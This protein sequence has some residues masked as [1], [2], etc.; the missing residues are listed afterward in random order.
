ME[1]VQQ[2]T[3]TEKNLFLFSLPILNKNMEFFTIRFY[4]YFLETESVKLFADTKFEK[5]HKMFGEAVNLILTYITD[6][7]HLEKHIQIL[8][9]SHVRYGVEKNNINDFT[10]SFMSALKET[11]P[12][13]TDNKLLTIWLKVIEEIMKMFDSNL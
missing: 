8:A 6:S 12:E 13:N 1:S 5:Q 2:L 7:E 10:R 9:M 3:I 4:H 11:L